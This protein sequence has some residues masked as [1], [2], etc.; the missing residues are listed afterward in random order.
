MRMLGSL[1]D[2]L[3]RPPQIVDDKRVECPLLKRCIAEGYCLDIN[4]QRLGFIKPDVLTEAQQ[5][6]GLTIEQVS[7][8]CES[9]PH[10]PLKAKE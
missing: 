6:T 2:W 3:R 7:A 5:E 9:C 4:F 1:W 10:L 8:V